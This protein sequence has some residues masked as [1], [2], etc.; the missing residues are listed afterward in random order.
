MGLLLLILAQAAATPPKGLASARAGLVELTARSGAEV[1]IAARMLDGEDLLVSPDLSFHAASTMKV[2]VMIA[3]FQASKEGR[4][5]L[6]EKIPVR[7]EF[8]SIVDGSPYSLEAE[9]DSD[10]DVYKLVGSEVSMRQLCESMITVSSNLA[11]NIL[12]EKL[13]VDVIQARVKALG[14]DGMNV[15][16]PLEDGKAFLAGINNTTTA[17]GLETLLIALATGHAVDPKSDEAMV[18]ILKHQHFSDGIP[19]GLPPGTVVAH[20]T[21]EITKIQHDAAIVYAPRPFVL[22]VLVRGIE[23]R[24]KSTALIADIARAVYA[25]TQDPRP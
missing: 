17:R 5:S 8:K 21:G 25:A 1:A 20:K 15:V 4:L 24:T 9:N 2:P 7:N 6:D 14:A 22:V 11:T 10:P 12:V 19:A 13:G 23:D 18:E 16:R 3:L